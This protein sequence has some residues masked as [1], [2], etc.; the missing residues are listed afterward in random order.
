METLRFALGT[1]IFAVIIFL[2]PIVGGG[3]THAENTLPPTLTKFSYQ[4]K[5]DAINVR[6]GRLVVNRNSY[7]LST[8]TRVHGPTGELISA[9]SIRKGIFIA[10]NTFA[11]GNSV[12]EIWIIPVD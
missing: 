3:L 5:V 9:D 10:F 1:G 4:G 2:Q 12:S 7:Q 11:Y 6:E 8:D